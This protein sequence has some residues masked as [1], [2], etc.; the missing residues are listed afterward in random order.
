MSFS[1]FR[2]A[3]AGRDYHQYGLGYKYGHG[4]LPAAFALSQL[5]KLSKTNA[6][7]QDNFHRLGEQLGDLPHFVTPS[8]P[9]VAS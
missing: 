9:A 1:D 7:A 3:D 5:R 6:W 2:P 4:N 8:S